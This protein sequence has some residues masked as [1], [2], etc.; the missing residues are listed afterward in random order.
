MLVCK[1]CGFKHPTNLIPHIEEAHAELASEELDALEGYVA[2]HDCEVE[3]IRIVPKLSTK[4]TTKAKP[5]TKAEASETTEEKVSSSSSVKIA[6]IEINLGSGGDYVPEVNEAYFFPKFTADVVLD[7]NEKKKVLLTGHTG[8]GKSSLFEQLAAR[9]NQNILRV[10]LN[11]QITIGDFTGMWTVR[12]GET[13]WV[14][15]ILPKCM[16]EG[17]WLV[18]EEIDFAEPAILSILNTVLENNGKL[19]L[20]EKGHEVIKP[21]ENFRILAT[22]NTVG[23]MSSFRSLYQGTSIMN[24]A[25]LDRFRCYLVDYLPAEEESKVISA[26][27][28]KITPKI[29]NVIVRVAGMVREAFNK[30]EIS[31]TFST[32]RVLDWSELMIRY[33]NPLQAAD[34]AIFSKI[35]REDT[36]VIKGIISR[37]MV[38]N[39]ETK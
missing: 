25:F 14:D 12:G 35:S 38:G 31:C 32:R 30:E 3:D 37:V 9:A 5:K 11:A 19:V 20:K 36:E 33:K 29:A 39:S 21:H 10:N 16:K 22:A 26:T 7:L 13:V 15:G 4:A 6:G 24:E 28:P 18:L 8:C 17:N 34:V 1:S 23:A 27:I 2:L